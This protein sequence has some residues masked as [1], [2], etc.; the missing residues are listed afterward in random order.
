MH[1]VAT[2]RENLLEEKCQNLVVHPKL[3]LDVSQKNTTPNVHQNWD[4]G[5]LDWETKLE[6]PT[7]SYRLVL[8]SRN[9]CQ[10]C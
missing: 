7:T 10:W 5:F 1:T 4:E 9:T 6:K 2:G 3:P 8:N